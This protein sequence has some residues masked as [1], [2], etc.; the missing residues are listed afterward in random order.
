MIK[1]RLGQLEQEG[2]VLK[3]NREKEFIYWLT[4]CPGVGAVTVKKAGERAGG[5]ENVYYI[6]GTE[7]RRMGI[8]RSEKQCLQ[9][10]RWKK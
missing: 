1:D 7:L 5:F 10:D 2:P 4:R 6:E 3:L 9:F 8:L